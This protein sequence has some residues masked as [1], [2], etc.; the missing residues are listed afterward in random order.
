MIH[1]VE[2]YRTGIEHLA[3]NTATIKAIQSAYPEQLLKVYG[4]PDL[5]AALECE[6]AGVDAIEFVPIKIAA[7]NTSKWR[8][9]GRDFSVIK[10]LKKLMAAE[11]KCVL[12]SVS[13]A[14][15]LALVLLRLKQKLL[16][17]IHANLAVTTRRPKYNIAE[18]WFRE[19]ALIQFLPRSTQFCVL[20]QG[21]AATATEMMPELSGRLGVIPHPVPEDVSAKP[22][23]PVGKPINIGLCGLITPQKGLNQMES[24]AQ[25]FH[26]RGAAFHLCGRLHQQLAARGVEGAD[27]FNT[28]PSSDRIER[29]AFVAHM[30][31]L[32]LGA[33]FFTGQYYQLTASGVLLDFMALGLPLFGYRNT[34]IEAIE[35]E[36]G[37]IGW[38]CEPGAESTLLESLLN[39]DIDACYQLRRDNLLAA[40]RQRSVLE[41]GKIVKGL[42]DSLAV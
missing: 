11:D 29:N 9:I 10:K 32:D 42:Y 23:G 17:V 21:A 27:N 4:E 33:F 35:A 12:L 31:S 38:F 6:L 24:L 40:A 3:F 13:P 25:Q 1:V 20:E 34:A 37:V 41:T 28:L 26:G 8:R 22:A 19:R 39:R 18:R 30:A 16:A 7:R 2:F 15:T 5:L 36:F 14:A